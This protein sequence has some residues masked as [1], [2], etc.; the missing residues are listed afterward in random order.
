MS[1]IVGPLLTYGVGH[2]AQKG[3]LH[4]YQAIFICLVSGREGVCE[5]EAGVNPGLIC[6]LLT[7]PDWSMQHSPRRIH[8]PQRPTKRKIPSSWHRPTHRP[9]SPTCEPNRSKHRTMGLDASEGM[10]TRSKDVGMVVHV[11]PRGA[12]L[13]RARRIR[14]AHLSWDGVRR[15]RD[16]L[17]ADANGS[18]SDRLVVVFDLGDK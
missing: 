4:Q 16:D 2:A 9:R 5:V 8:A 14:A 7:G 12:S 18:D 10:P 15:V 1:A 13:W 17:D 11:S 3:G 6:V